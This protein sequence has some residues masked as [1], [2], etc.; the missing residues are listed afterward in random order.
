[1]RRIILY[2]F[3]VAVAGSGCASVNTGGERRPPV[4]AAPAGQTPVKAEPSADESELASFVPQVRELSRRARPRATNAQVAEQCLPELAA[5]MARQSAAPTVG[6]EIALAQTLAGLGIADQAYEHFARAARLDPHA[7]AAWD[8]LARIWRDWGFPGLG[9]GDAYR[10][11]SAEPQSPGAR[12]TLGTIL[13]YLGHGREARTQFEQAL[14]LNPGVA[15][16]QNN[17][18]YSW[19]LEGRAD[20]ALQACRLALAVDPNMIVA[21]N[22]LALATAMAGDPAG[23]ARIFG[24]VGG[25]SA[26]QYNLGIAYLAQGRYSAAADAFDRAARLQP[27]VKLAHIR[28]DQARQ[29]ALDAQDGGRDNHE[30]R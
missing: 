7:G 19:L 4:Q 25:E 6:N 22:N 27:A 29:L 12:N 23:A 20:T 2:L 17:L 28:A 11:V 1:M 9:L 24:E 3:A 8:G 21:R 30:R 5:A 16:A 18:C 15:Y 26:S 13:E 14:A 10:A